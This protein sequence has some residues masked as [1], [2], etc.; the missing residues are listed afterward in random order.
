MKMEKKKRKWLKVVYRSAICLLTAV[1]MLAAGLFGVLA[2]VCLGPS[3]TARDLF[4]VSMTETS[5]G[6]VFARIFFSQEE[7]DG[8]K[9]QNSVIPSEEN[10]DTSLIQV[11]E[12]KEAEPIVIE[13]VSGSTYKGKIMLISDPGRLRV[14]TRGEFSMEARGKSVK[15]M[16]EENSAIAGINGGWFADPDGRGKGGMPIG[17]VISGGELL[18]GELDETYEIIGFD[19]NNVLFTGY[20]T[21]R[22]ALEM[23]IRDAVCFGPSL[24]VNGEPITVKGLGSGL[25]P[26]SAIGQRADGTVLLLA[27]EG[28]RASSL[29]A[30]LNDIIGIF[31]E[32]GAVNA[33]NLDGGMSSILYYDGEYITE[34]CSPSGPRVVPT[35]FIVE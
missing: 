5:M 32:Y 26:R 22:K 8:I 2:T 4:V 20:V 27:V 10:T 9:A 16:C 14:A 31:A 13:E 30:T 23:G 21:A 24:I 3:S 34:S 11:E 18:H 6:T 28:R 25:N 7:I 33:A 17:L 12:N 29:G 15:Q 19:N 35:A 1:L